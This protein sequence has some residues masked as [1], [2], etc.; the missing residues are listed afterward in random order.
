MSDASNQESSLSIEEK[1][2]TVQ[3]QRTL[4]PS[5]GFPPWKFK[6]LLN[7]PYTLIQELLAKHGEPAGILGPGGE[8]FFTTMPEGVKAIFSANPEIFEAFGFETISPFVG[9]ESILMMSGQKHKAERK[10]LMPPFHGA[11]MRAYADVIL[12]SVQ[13]VTQSWKQGQVITMLEAMQEI[14]LRV[15]IRAVFGVQI[16]ASVQA[17]RDA[18]VSKIDAMSPWLVLFEWL[19]VG[20]AGLSPWDRYLKQDRALNDLL[21][22]EI[23]ARREASFHGEDIL[24]LM[25]S[26]RY[27]DGSAMTDEH[28]RDELVTLLFAGHET[29]AISLTWALHC[30]WADPEVKAALLRE[31]QTVRPEQ[32]Q[33][34]VAELPYLTATIHEVLRLYPAVPI[35]A[36]KLLQPF[37]L[38]G[39]TIPAGRAVG[40]AIGPLHRRPD[41]YPEPRAFNPERFLR[42]EYTPFEFAPFGG[43]A[44]RCLGAAFSLYESKLVLA[45]MLQ[46][47][48]LE[49]I[50][51]KT[52]LMERR[53]VT[54]GP[55]GGVRMRVVARH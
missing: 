21:M 40:V 19:R 17:C 28:V 25:L 33:D 46:K 8:V 47:F 29:T 43:G 31:L 41:L 24:S 9:P 27:D 10:L 48:E 11:R 34:A 15:I 35:V 53:N 7:D 14:S 4:P 36:R 20:F 37:E 45:A 26:A 5:V 13:D 32:G 44:R 18:V 1:R 42:R 3:A 38:L 51:K 16:P 55:K 49:L 52:P 30:C 39:Y 2:T 6:Q 54:L 12:E 50:D 23:K 22:A